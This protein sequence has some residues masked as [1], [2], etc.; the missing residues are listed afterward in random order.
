MEAMDLSQR[1]ACLG[2]LAGAI[3][4]RREE[5]IAG[6]IQTSKKIRRVAAGEVDLALARLGAFGEVAAR[7]AGRAPVGTVAVVFPGN[8]SI[9]N[10]VATI[11]TAFL[12]DNEVVGRFPGASRAWADQLEP[13]FLEHLPGVRFDHGA[14]QT[15]LEGALADP[16]VAV[17]MI[18]GDDAWAAGYEDR[19]RESRTKFI[20]EGPGKD[21]F[22]V[23]PGADLEKAARDAVR[24]GYYNAGQA[25]TSPERFYVHAGLVEEFVE[26]VVELTRAQVVG[27]PERDDVTIGPIVSRR[28]AARITAQLEDAAAR[29]ARTLIGG[30]IKEGRLADGTPVA[31]V[32]PTVLT[33]VN[34]LMT[35]MQDETFGPVIPVQEVRSAEEALR[36]AA[37]HRYG[38]AASLY[39]GT[40]ADAAVLAETHGQVFR[41]E[42]WIDYVGRHLHAPYGGR[43]QSGWV[44]A[45]E[46]GRFIRREGVRTN[47]LEFSRAAS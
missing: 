1:L 10:P 13:L 27:E 11:G 17:V 43:K 46:G 7:L 35:I 28:I 42:I 32:A 39:G 30:Q 31:Y 40:D 6:I 44:W 37:D 14:G 5:L 34:S 4:A 12:A 8:A 36:L 45:W 33:G 16:A 19:V 24:G 38:L 2:S 21:P 3:R 47:A 22:L 20:L 23:L 26:R 41:D 9:S 18:F 15:F 25:C 29:G